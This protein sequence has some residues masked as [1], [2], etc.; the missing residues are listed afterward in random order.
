MSVV[1]KIYDPIHGFIKLGELEAWLVDSPVFQ[2]LHDIRQLGVTYLVYPG[3][4]HTR[5]EH[6]L[7]VMHVATEIFDQITAKYPPCHAYNLEYWRQIV[8]LSALC[9]DLGHLPF[10]HVAEKILLGKGG[11]ERWTLNVIESSFLEPLWQKISCGDQGCCPR[12]DVIRISLG[13]EK[14]KE[15]N[16]PLANTPFTDWEKVMSQVITGDFFGADRIDYLLRDTKCTGVSYGLFD[17]AQLIEMLCILPDTDSQRLV[18]G[19]EEN[20]IESCEALLLAR[21]FMHKRVSVSFCKSFRL[22]HGPLH[23]S[24]L[25]VFRSSI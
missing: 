24:S 15:I 22:S 19:V 12:D 7:G 11:H 1:K 6:S 13:E 2:R 4:T 21:H 5:F 10:S 14:L 16:H 25:S 3:A 23:A 8:R 18:L 20:G 9:H 17:Y